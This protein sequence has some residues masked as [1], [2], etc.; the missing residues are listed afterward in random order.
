MTDKERV[1]RYISVLPSARQKAV[2]ERSFNIFIHYG[3]NTFTGKEWGDGTAPASLFAPTAQ[4]TDDWVRCAKSAGAAGVILTCKHH[5]GFCLWQTDTTDYSVRSSPY[6]DGKGDV[7]AEVAESCRKF[8]LK[9]GIY[10]SPWDRNSKFYGTD[11]YNDFYVRQLTE[12]LTRYGDIFCVWLDGAC[13]SYMDGRP[14][15]RYDFERYY[16]VVRE[17]QPGACISNCGPDIRWVGNEA[18]IARENER[19][20]VPAFAFDTQT[21]ADNSQHADG[22]GMKSVG[23]T[24][25]DLGSREVLDGHEKLIWYPAEADVSLR[26]GWFYH[27]SEDGRV[28]SLKNLLRI[29]YGTVGGNCLLLLNVPP[30]RSGNIAPADKRRLA[31]FGAALKSHFARPAACSYECAEETA[32]HPASNLRADDGAYFV[33]KGETC[34]VVMRFEGEKLV[35]KVLLRED[36]DFSE[37]IERADISA[38]CGGRWKKVASV[39]SVG[40]RRVAVFDRPR[41]CTAIRLDI[42]ESR[43]QPHL[44]CAIPYEYGGR[45]PRTPWYAPL[46]RLVHKLNYAVYVSRENAARRRA[47]KRAAKGSS[48]GEGGH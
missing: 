23:I 6:K 34:S 32:E 35:D 12:L 29:W 13:G 36:C 40:F 38:L 28:R 9:F 41:K 39:G 24:E 1:E 7:V 25:E 11:E 3:I 33:P 10:L 20:V 4:D 42:T 31:E 16:A 8:G 45:V 30:D 21:I 47:A 26:P 18:G 15:Q 19:S 37:R 43:S 22:D 48:Q 5:D 46:V 2:Q 14:C 27:S 44:A 17:L